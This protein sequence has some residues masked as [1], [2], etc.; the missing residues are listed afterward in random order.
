MISM[1]IGNAETL[2]DISYSEARRT[3]GHQGKMY[4]FSMKSS[5]PNKYHS[6]P[7]NKT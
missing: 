6:D 4:L 7:E 3:L 5:S 1:N 2:I